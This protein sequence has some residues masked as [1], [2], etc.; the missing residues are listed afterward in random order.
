MHAVIRTGGK[1]Y[2]VQEGDVLRVERLDAD[3]GAEIE[4]PALAVGEGAS[5][6]T[7]AEAEGARVR[8]RVRRHGRGRKVVVFKRKRRKDYRRTH[9]HRQPFTEIVIEAIEA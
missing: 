7:G 2:R 8:A 4:L 9:G 3:E 1:Q 5:L 6:R